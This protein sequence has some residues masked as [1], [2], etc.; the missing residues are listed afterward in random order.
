M[1]KARNWTR[2]GGSTGMEVMLRCTLVLGLSF[3]W[4]HLTPRLLFDLK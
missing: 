4:G 1:G 3:P 2:P